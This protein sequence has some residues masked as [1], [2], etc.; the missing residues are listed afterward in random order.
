MRI[1][2]VGGGPAGL[3]FSILIKR[4][5]P[6]TQVTVYERNRADDTFGW[7]VVFSD[8][9]LET[10]ERADPES[11]A[12]ITKNFAYWTD[13]ETYHG[14]E[15]VRST[16]HGFCGLARKKLLQIF[17][18]RA[19]ELGVDLQ[20]QKEVP[21]DEDF[22]DADLILA[23]DG[24]NSGLRAR[25]ADHFQP[26]LDWRKCRFSWLGTNKP[27]E[28]FTFVF[29]ENEHGLFQ[30]HAYPFKVGDEPLSTWIVECHEDVFQRAGLDQ[31]SEEETVRYMKKL[32]A[33]HLEGYELYSNRSI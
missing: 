9:T 2:S 1:V 3:Y 5:F 12:E 17:H 19:L 27:L 20:F 26:Q 4:A 16:G 23:S 29:R 7:G 22:P 11:Y 33:D 18:D 15:V 8:E 25:F 10:F 13:I 30:V 32:F 6:D 14:D 21:V 24:I 28:A 31:A